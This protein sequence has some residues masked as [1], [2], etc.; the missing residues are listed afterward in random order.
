[1]II[2]RIIII[3]TITDYRIN[4]PSIHRFIMVDRTDIEH[5]IT[6]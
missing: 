6:K 1:M 4:E 3:K 2:A 5:D